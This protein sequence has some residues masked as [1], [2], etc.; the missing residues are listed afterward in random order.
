MHQYVVAR[1]NKWADCDDESRKY[2]WR[3]LVAIF[4]SVLR[5]V[6]VGFNYLLVFWM[7]GVKTW[8]EYCG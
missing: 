8:G 4:E 1:F 2:A 3:R 6:W 5:E 7:D